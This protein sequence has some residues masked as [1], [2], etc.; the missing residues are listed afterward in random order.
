MLE[1]FELLFAI[2]GGWV[3]SILFLIIIRLIRG[4][5]FP[6]GAVVIENGTSNESYNPGYNIFLLIGMGLISFLNFL[7]VFLCIFNFWDSISRYIAFDFPKWINWIG[8]IGIW[9]Q[10]G[11]GVAVF[12]YNVNYTPAYKSMKSDYVLATGGPY[13]YMRH[14]MYTAKAILVIFFFLAT[15]IWLSLLGALSWLGLSAQAKLEEEALL[16]KYGKKYQEYMNDTGRF[17]PKRIN[18]KF[19]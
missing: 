13:K 17:F 4:K 14:P 11:W 5:K 7:I 1:R 10:D 18:L 6:N 9:I 16:K 15:G 12:S 19:S 2:V 3:V 8:L